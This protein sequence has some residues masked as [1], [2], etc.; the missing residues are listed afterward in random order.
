MNPALPL[1]GVRSLA[2]LALFL[3]VS[4]LPANAVLLKETTT[5]KTF[6]DWCLNQANLSIETKRTVDVLLKEAET[7]DCNQADKRL[8]RIT[9]LSLPYKQITDLRPLSG[10]TNLTKLHL[11]YNQIANLKPLSTL[12]NLTLLRLEGNQIADIKP[13][14]RLTKLGV[15]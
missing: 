2:T 11:F 6:A 4:S 12:T 14:S 1:P 13:L 7:T 8:S 3:F 10:L 5:P 9:K 15:L